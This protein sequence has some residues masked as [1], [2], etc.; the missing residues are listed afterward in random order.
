MFSIPLSIIGA[1]LALALTN[2]AMSIYGMLG[3]VM[4][5]GLVAKNAILLVDF[6]ND[7]LK[8]GKSMNEALTQAV[9][10]RIRPILMTA[11]SVIVGMLPIALTTGAGAELRN[12]LAW[13]II[14]GM[15][16]S[17][18]LTLIVVPVMYKIMHSIKRKSSEKVKLDIEQM[19]FE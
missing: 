7:A 5:I 8:E 18:F 2:T 11:L 14:G 16:L 1:F 13:V 6:A 10:I 19:M 12:G 15:V 3:L 4:L 17:T 9:R